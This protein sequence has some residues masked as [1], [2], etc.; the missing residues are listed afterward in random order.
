MYVVLRQ[1]LL[2]A[3]LLPRQRLVH[4]AVGHRLV[5]VRLIRSCFQVLGRLLHGLLFV[6]R[7]ALAPD[8]VQVDFVGD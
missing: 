1:V 5:L 8:D 6:A 2:E 3:L 7:D 4:I